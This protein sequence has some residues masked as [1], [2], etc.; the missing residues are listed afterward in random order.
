V[1]N[2]HTWAWPQYLEISLMFLSL[3]YVAGKNGK[4]RL[5]T[6]GS[7]ERYSFP[8]KLVNVALMIFILV[9]GGFFGARP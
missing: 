7:P 2:V 9:F 8:M 6:D 5:E 1:I 3:I 4:P